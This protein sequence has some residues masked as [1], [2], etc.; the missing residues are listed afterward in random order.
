MVAAREGAAWASM[1]TS[2]VWISA[3]RFGSVAVSA[4]ARRAARS[5]S[6]SSTKA[7]SVVGPP[8]A[9]CSTWPMRIRLGICSVPDSGWRSPAII[10]NSVVLPV[11]LRPTKPVRAP[12]G[13]A[14]D[15]WSNSMRGPSR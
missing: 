5:L 4:S 7:I 2:R 15:A 10:R 13:I 8:G 3:M 12:V 6:A 1:S 11:P 14:A 9:S